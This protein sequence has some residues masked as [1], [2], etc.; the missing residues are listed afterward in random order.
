MEYWEIWNEPDLFT[1]EKNKVSPTWSGTEEEF[2]ELY[3]VTAKHLKTC[4][5]HL[6]IGGPALAGNMSWA[7]RFLA[8]IDA[9]LDF[10]SWHCYACKVEQML[11]LS[12]FVRSLL[13]K[14]GYTDTESILNE[15]N[16]VRGWDGDNIVYSHDHRGKIKG[17]AFSSA[18]MCA[19]QYSSA[20]MLMY[21]DARPNEFWNGLFDD[22]VVGRVLK[23]YYPFLM[24]NTL[25]RL[26][27]CVDISDAESE[28]YA[29]AAKNENEAAVLVTHYN[30]D[31]ATDAKNFYIDMSGFGSDDGVDVEIYL[32]D[33]THDNELVGKATYYGERFG[34]DLSFPNFTSY[35][36][37]MKKR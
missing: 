17:A 2:F 7:E 14:Y 16:Y 26:G 6:K 22:T 33:G 27:T 3:N 5:P 4:F 37:K 11:D 28:A 8:K 29:C 10:F 36:I 19:C 9:P 13:D 18:A 23:G 21:Y 25:Y 12:K 24:F 34:L 30:D 35:L 1:N 32:L 15:W 31:D 20:D